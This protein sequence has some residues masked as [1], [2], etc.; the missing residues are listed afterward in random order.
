[1]TKLKIESY[2][3]QIAEEKIGKRTERRKVPWKNLATCVPMHVAVFAL[4]CHEYP[5]VIMLQVNSAINISQ[6]QNI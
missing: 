4:I 1:M 3:F 6:A 5:L 2:F